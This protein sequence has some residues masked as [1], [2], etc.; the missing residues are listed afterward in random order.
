MNNSKPPYDSKVLKSFSDK[1]LF[2]RELKVLLLLREK[3]LCFEGTPL[4]VSSK[5]SNT[6][7]EILMEELG[8]NV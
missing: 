5:E 8:I 1:N 4:L 2:N 7:S 6:N 3:N